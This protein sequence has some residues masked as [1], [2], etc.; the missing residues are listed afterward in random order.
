[1]EVYIVLY[2]SHDNECSECRGV[3]FTKNLAE[4]KIKEIIEKQ[5]DGIIVDNND[6]ADKAEIQTEDNIWI[7]IHDNDSYC[8]Y[9]SDA[10]YWIEKHPVEGMHITKSA[11]SSTI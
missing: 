4:A 5:W 6:D 1:M 8:L 11:K 2:D 7:F 3:F 9:R 10:M